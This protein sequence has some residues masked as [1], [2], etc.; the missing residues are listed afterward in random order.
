MARMIFAFNIYLF[1]AGIIKLCTIDVI[2]ITVA[3]T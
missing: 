3:N 1:I 2:Q